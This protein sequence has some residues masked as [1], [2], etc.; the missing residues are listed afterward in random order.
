MLIKQGGAGGG[1][2]AGNRPNITFDGKWSGWYVDFY[3]EK[4]YWEAVFYTSG[5]L[6]VK[7]PCVADAWAIG[8]GACCNH[9]CGSGR[10]Q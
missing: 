4:A 8:A 5:T 2:D 7:S 3:G 1:V 10:G 9:W 6:S